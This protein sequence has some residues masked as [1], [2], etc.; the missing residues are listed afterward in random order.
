MTYLYRQGNDPGQRFDLVTACPVPL[1]AAGSCLGELGPI[2]L[3]TI[4]LL[5]GRDP[6]Y[7]RAVTLFPSSHA[8]GLYILLDCMNHA[9]THHRYCVCVRLCVLARALWIK[10]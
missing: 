10:E 4:T 2:D 6:L 7:T 5:H 3:S 1:E 9:L 8:Q